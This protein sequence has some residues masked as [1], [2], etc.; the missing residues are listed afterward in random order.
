MKTWSLLVQKLEMSR[1]QQQSIALSAGPCVTT[2]VNAHGD[3]EFG[4]G[5][6]GESQGGCDNNPSTD[7][8]GPKQRQH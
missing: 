5:W 4:Q 1:W 3:V 2:Q 6:R 8:P 7:R